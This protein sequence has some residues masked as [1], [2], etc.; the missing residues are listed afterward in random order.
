[1]LARRDLYGSAS[2]RLP[3]STV[4]AA[5]ERGAK[6]DWDADN[7]QQ[8]YARTLAEHEAT[9]VDRA[10]RRKAARERWR[11]ERATFVRAMLANAAGT[12]VGGA[13]LAL[14]AQAQGFL[15][16]LTK[17]SWLSALVG[18]GGALMGM[19]AAWSSTKAADDVKALK[20]T[21]LELRALRHR[22][23]HGP[24]PSVPTDLWRET[25]PDGE[26]EPG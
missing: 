2:P 23:R 14:G 21:R 8:V 26:D 1:M 13:L 3:P 16:G 19:A 18:L 11:E 15:G 20:L 5:V 22:E 9:Q 6:M 10:A 12:V 24:D 4:T 17:E 25:E 7:P